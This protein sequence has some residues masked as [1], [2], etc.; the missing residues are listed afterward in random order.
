MVSSTGPG[1]SNFE[2]DRSCSTISSRRMPE[3]AAFH[4]DRGVI[5]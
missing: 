1:M 3:D 5:R 4:S 2:S